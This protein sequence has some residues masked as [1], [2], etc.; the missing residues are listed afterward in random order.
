MLEEDDNI[1]TLYEKLQYSEEEKEKQIKQNEEKIEDNIIDIDNEKK[2]EI[3][4]NVIYDEENNNKDNK[5]ND[6][7]KENENENRIHGNEINENEIHEG[8]LG[9]GI[10]IDENK[11]L[12]EKSQDYKEYNEINPSDLINVEEN[13]NLQIEDDNEIKSFKSE[14]EI[15]KQQIKEKELLIK[16][17]QIKKENVLGEIL[18]PEEKINELNLLLEEEKNNTKNNL[19]T[20]SQQE[21]K[22]ESMRSMVKELDNQIEIQLKLKDQ[23]ANDKLNLLTKE[24]QRYIQ[25]INGYKIKL[26]KLNQSIQKTNNKIGEFEEEKKN[27][28]EILIKQEEKLNNYIDRLNELEIIFK[29]KN[30]SIKET[31]AYSKELIKLIEEQKNNI[32][33]LKNRQLNNNKRYS[34]N[35]NNYRSTDINI[36]NNFVLPKINK[37]NDTIKINNNNNKNMN[38]EFI[39]YKE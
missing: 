25:E 23:K 27:M 29:R 15:L 33:Q 10:K 3:I 36:N 24:S 31:E 7:N 18:N 19:N 14:I 5:N 8:D 20:I 2:G 37:I 12:I 6:E 32:K 17:F 26:N 39:I 4:D 35:Y 38:I 16:D 34:S 13:K 28:Q 9:F 30:K 22:I 21:N 1:Q 11:E